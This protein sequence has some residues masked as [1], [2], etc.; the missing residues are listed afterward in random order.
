MI[1]LYF[2]SRI[3][4]DT[5]DSVDCGD[6]VADWLC[7]Y[8]NR[9]GLRLHYSSP[10][11]EKRDASKAKKPWDHPAKPGDMV[12]LC[13]FDANTSIPFQIVIMDGALYVCTF[14]SSIFFHYG[15]AFVYN[16]YHKKKNLS[17]VTITKT[18]S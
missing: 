8:F 14:R 11:L 3:K 1:H 5:I 2:N 6:E 9:T 17:I 10:S 15:F 4:T 16:T 18:D 7:R 12:R 13:D